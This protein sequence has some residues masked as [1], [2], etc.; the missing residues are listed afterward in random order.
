MNDGGDEYN[1]EAIL[2]AELSRL[3]LRESLL[4]YRKRKEIPGASRR[5][6]MIA[7]KAK[8]IALCSNQLMP[9]RP[10]GSGFFFPVLL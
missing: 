2:T 6:T 4:K 1:E 5:N 9:V 7:P 3:L 10:C 8:F